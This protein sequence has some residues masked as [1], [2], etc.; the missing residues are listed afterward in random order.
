LANT[1]AV[2]LV[3][4]A[5]QFP[6]AVFVASQ[7]ARL[8]P[9]DDTDIVI[10]SDADADMS[11]A[12]DFGV[13]ARLFA[14]AD[15]LGEIDFPTA[16]YITK[17]A[18]YRYFLPD[19]LGADYQRILYLDVD[20]Y[21]HDARVFG[22]LDLDLGDH[23]V[24]AVRDSMIA[25]TGL[26]MNANELCETLTGGSR[27]YLNSGIQLIDC[28]RFL[29]REIRRK[30]VRAIAR[31]KLHFHYNDQTAINR[32]LDGDWLELSPSFNMFVPLW[33][34]F[35]RQVCEP[36]LVHFAG[37]NKPWHGPAFIEDHPVKPEL[38]AFLAVTPWKDFRARFFNVKTALA[39]PKLSVGPGL[40]A[41]KPAVRSIMTRKHFDMKGFVGY[42]TNTPFA[43]VAAGLTSPRFD[44]IPP[45]LAA[46]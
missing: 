10:V 8:N 29:K 14:L 36:V 39:A 27:K 9:R 23:A 31:G 41:K 21:V 11:K 28:N 2:A 12:A 7:L 15:K 6:I 25:H 20:I 26:P 18:Y 16:N 4:D 45:N 46:P 30:I 37:P 32:V 42:L 44:L 35:V 1:F 34:S 40:A 38:E 19:L 24:G 22:L 17:A 5:N 3:T 43:D 33:N 13:P